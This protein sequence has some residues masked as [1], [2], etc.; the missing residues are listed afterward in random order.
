VN[1]DSSWF[2]AKRYGYGSGL[3]ISWQGWVVLA[4]YLAIVLGAAFLFADRW[5]PLAAT[6]VPSTL[7]FMLICARK[8]RGGWHWRWGS[9][10]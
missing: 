6:I 9:N 2:A 7:L 5:A 4:I 1:D 3:P 8:T 10:D